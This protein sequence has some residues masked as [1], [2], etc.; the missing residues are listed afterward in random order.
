MVDF[1]KHIPCRGVMIGQRTFVSG[2]DK[3]SDNIGVVDLAEPSS[4]TTH[5][6]TLIFQWS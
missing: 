1:N 3:R 2:I 5:F 4:P 6:Y